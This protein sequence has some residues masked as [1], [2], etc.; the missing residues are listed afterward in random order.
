M[1]IKTLKTA[2]LIFVFNLSISLTDKNF[3]NNHFTLYLLKLQIK[4]NA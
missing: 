3:N 4:V 1:H 2:N